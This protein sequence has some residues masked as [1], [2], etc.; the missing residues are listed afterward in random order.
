MFQDVL[1]KYTG[2]SS[3][4]EVSRDEPRFVSGLIGAEYKVSDNGYRE[5]WSA[6]ALDGASPA[7]TKIHS[8]VAE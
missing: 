1:K 6:G 3:F 4:I 5:Y 2:F 7:H 8:L